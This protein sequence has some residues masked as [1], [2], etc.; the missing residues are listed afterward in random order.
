VT[1]YAVLIS[2]FPVNFDTIIIIMIIIIIIIITEAAIPLAFFYLVMLLD[3][4]SINMNDIS[5]LLRQS[6]NTQLCLCCYVLWYNLRLVD[7][8]IQSTKLTELLD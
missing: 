3:F 4:V 2:F 1:E 6:N 8:L 5:A 7:V